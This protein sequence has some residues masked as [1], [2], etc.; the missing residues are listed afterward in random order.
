MI[1]LCIYAVGSATTALALTVVI[2]ALGW[3]ILEGI[4]AALVLPA[5]H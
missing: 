3:S 1:G 2:L 5:L 4:G